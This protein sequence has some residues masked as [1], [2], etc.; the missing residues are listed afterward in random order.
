[1]ARSLA[2]DEEG[3]STLGSLIGLLVVVVA[4]LGFYFGYVV[5]RFPPPPDRVLP[6][7]TVTVNY[8]GTFEN[9]LVFDTS[10]ATVARD[11]ASFP[12][13][14]GFSWRSTWNTL[15][16]DVGKVPPEVI[17]GFELGVQGLSVGDTTTIRVPPELGYGAPD[18]AKI[19]EKP[20]LEFVPVRRTMDEDTFRATYGTEPVSGS[21]VTD[22]IFG[23]TVT[24]EVAD[25][26][27]RVTNSP[28]LGSRVVHPWGA[29]DADVVAIDSTA[30][31]GAGRI[32][33]LHRLDAAS[34]DR[35]GR[36]TVADG[37][38]TVEFVV[39]AVDTAAGTYTLNFEQDPPKGRVLVFQV[40]IVRIT[41]TV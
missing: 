1:M 40:T 2:H 18:P 6:G 26:I 20:L 38:S 41:P 11:N 30:D 17:Q 33:V 9:G 15:Q 28:L 21:S 39:T 3:L 13:A 22:P 34:V 12:K 35:V 37:R 16:F 25:T 36:R 10:L 4:I 5:P 24:V 8:I 23:W 19:Q 31:E 7:D 27:V 32:E 14:F 29:W